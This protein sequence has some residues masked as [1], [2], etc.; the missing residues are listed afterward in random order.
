MIKVIEH[1]KFKQIRCPE[2]QCWFSYEKEDTKIVHVELN[3]YATY[4]NCPECGEEIRL[5]PLVANKEN[6][7]KLAKMLN[8]DI[9]GCVVYIGNKIYYVHILKNIVEEI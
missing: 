1:R 8:C 7:I 6:I 3:N 4:V 9:N 5:K 2:C